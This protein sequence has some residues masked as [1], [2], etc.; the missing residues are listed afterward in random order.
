[1]GCVEEVHKDQDAFF[2]MITHVLEI[3]VNSL[4][5]RKIL[6]D[7]TVKL[8]NRLGTI[9][10]QFINCHASYFANDFD[11]SST[12]ECSAHRQVSYSKVRQEGC[13]FTRDE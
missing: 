5:F 9:H 13:S 2:K 8:Q 11:V 1:M 12:S 6:L 7:K 4:N 10:F 3:A